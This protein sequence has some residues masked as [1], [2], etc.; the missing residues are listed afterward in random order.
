MAERGALAIQ[1]S[2]CMSG[3]FSKWPHL[4]YPPF[5]PLLWH[6]RHLWLDVAR[7]VAHNDIGPFSANMLKKRRF[8]PLTSVPFSAPFRKGIPAMKPPDIGC[9]LLLRLTSGAA[10][11]L[12][13]LLGSRVEGKFNFGPSSWRT[14]MGTENN[15]APKCLIFM[16]ETNHN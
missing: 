4:E 8:C 9:N 5:N 15:W 3:V 12:T 13:E 16:P 6:L 11:L 2:T 7:G 14:K 10:V 1:L